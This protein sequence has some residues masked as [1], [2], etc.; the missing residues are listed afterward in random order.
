MIRGR[1]TYQKEPAPKQL[2][3][4]VRVRVHKYRTHPTPNF[5]WGGLPIQATPKPIVRIHP[6]VSTAPVLG[7]LSGAQRTCFVCSMMSRHVGHEVVPR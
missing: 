4:W 3:L 5:A 7:N 1:D 2:T 6:F